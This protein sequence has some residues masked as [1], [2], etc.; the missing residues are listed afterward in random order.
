M[1]F[2]SCIHQEKSD[3]LLQIR[4]CLKGSGKPYHIHLCFFSRRLKALLESASSG[5]QASRKPDTNFAVS[6]C[7]N[8]LRGS[9]ILDSYTLWMPFLSPLSSIIGTKTKIIKGGS[10]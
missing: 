5:E 9:Y 4:P 8:V 1:N 10:N 2:S 3:H 6:N 7:H